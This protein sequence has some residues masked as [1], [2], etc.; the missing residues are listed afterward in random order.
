MILSGIL[1]KLKAFLLFL[2]PL[3]LFSC[4]IDHMLD[5]KAKHWSFFFSFL[6]PR[7]YLWM[8]V[9]RI[10]RFSAFLFSFPF[11][12][13]FLGHTKRICI[14]PLQHI[15]DCK[16][17]KEFHDIKISEDNKKFDIVKGNLLSTSRNC[18]ILSKM[19]VSFIILWSSFKHLFL[20]FIMI[21]QFHIYEFFMV[22]LF[23]VLLWVFDI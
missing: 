1:Q 22:L 20:F 9:K 13:N 17:K 14:I 18:I 4:N 10:Y 23:S 19:G 3:I 8:I 5:K 7:I 11:N 15:L 16:F 21:I 12:I 2:P 6:F